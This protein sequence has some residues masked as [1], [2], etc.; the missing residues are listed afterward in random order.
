MLAV[1]QKQSKGHEVF[2]VHKFIFHSLLRHKLPVFSLGRSKAQCKNPDQ[3]T[4]NHL[5]QT[6]DPDQSISGA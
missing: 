3:K 6:S 1:L 4:I 2:F 5:S